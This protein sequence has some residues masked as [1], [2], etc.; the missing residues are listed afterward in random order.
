[1][2]LAV[3]MSL[4]AT[5]PAHADTVRPRFVIIIDTSGSMVENAIRV[6]T[7]G[8]GSEGDPGCD[9]D[10]NGAYDDS[11]LYQ[12]KVAL[13]DT[14]TAF[15]S[16]EFSLS[17]YQQNELGQ[18]CTTPQNCMAMGTGADVCVGGRCGY[19]VPSNSTDYNECTGGTATGN[20]CIRCADPADDPVEVWYNGNTC[21]GP[22]NPARAA[23]ACR[24]T[25]WCRSP[26]PGP[27]TCPSC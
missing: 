4:V 27:P 2:A 22:N 3:V 17:R 14:M 23:S 18:P 25:C 1:M 5:G 9:L 19:S 8:D 10:G 16:A 26:A 21:C 20:G 6:R 24:P 12:A 13:R 7:H 11:K 15:G